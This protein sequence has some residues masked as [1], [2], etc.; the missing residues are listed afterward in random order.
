MAI[1]LD[2]EK[3]VY[4]EEYYQLCRKLNKFPGK[5]DIIRYLNQPYRF[6]KLFG[7][8]TELKKQA[9]EFYPDLELMAVPAELTYTDLEEYKLSLQKKS[10]KKN[11]DDLV[12]TVSLL[13][14]VE[15]FAEKV[16]SGRIEVKPYKTKSQN[17]DRIFNLVLSDLH[18]GADI[19]G[20]E[21][22]SLTYGKVEEARR[23][24]K[25]ITETC[26]YKLE[27]RESTELN[28]FL[29]G[30]LIQG[31]LAHD[32]RDGSELSEQ[33]CR[34]I[35]LLGQGLGILCEHFKKV[36]VLCNTGNHDRNIGRHH[37][38][39]IHGKFD[40][41]ATMIFYSLKKMFQDTPNIKFVIPKTPYV[42]VQNFDKRI[43]ATHGDTV[44]GVGSVGKAINIGNIEKQINKI[45]ASLKD[46]L[47][48]NAYI[49]GHL[50]HGTVSLLPNGATLLVN[51]GLPPSDSFGVSL[52]SLESNSGQLL[53]ESIEG[54]AVGDIRFI[55]VNSE[56]DKDSSLDKIIQKWG[57]YNE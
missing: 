28:V 1:D 50:H 15:T 19:D 47:E 52:G 24:A 55:R 54:L 16:F 23:F 25:V 56:T 4:L 22:G 7:G 30:D 31:L 43:F 40:S 57:S 18:F 8:V 2:A 44:L 9:I 48:F 34:A 42:T 27:K 49:V 6:E 13:D 21:T 26:G 32:P 14:Y 10:Q 41:F 33:F 35:H 51:P 38:R 5:R 12:K 37:G 45:N 3:S 17:N 46:D 53:F 20:E 29:L 39:A 36:T 11:N